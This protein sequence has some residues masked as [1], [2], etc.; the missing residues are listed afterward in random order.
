[1]FEAEHTPELDEYLKKISWT[2]NYV[3]Q[4]FGL[5]RVSDR[6][7]DCAGHADAPRPMADNTAAQPGFIC[8]VNLLS[9]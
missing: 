1:M 3:N 7:G 2:V 8:P 5:D 9:T 6:G 4:T